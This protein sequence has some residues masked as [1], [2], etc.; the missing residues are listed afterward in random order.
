MVSSFNT[1]QTV[2]NCLILFLILKYFCKLYYIAASFAIVFCPAQHI[3][4]L[5]FQSACILLFRF[6]IQTLVVIY[7][8]KRL[9]YLTCIIFLSVQNFL[10]FYLDLNTLCRNHISDFSIPIVCSIIFL[11]SLWQQ[12]LMQCLT[13]FTRFLWNLLKANQDEDN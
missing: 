4:I 1:E 10:H 7:W 2:M 9:S 6:R 8:S 13:G 12:N 11:K 3:G 5:Q